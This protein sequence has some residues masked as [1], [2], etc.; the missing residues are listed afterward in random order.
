MGSGSDLSYAKEIAETLKALE[1]PVKAKIMSAHKLTEELLMT[2]RDY[3]IQEN[4][5]IFY[6]AI[7][8]RSN[9]L[10]GVIEANTLSPV[11]NAPPYSDKFGGMDILSSLRMPS[12]MS[13]ATVLEPEG[14][15][16]HIARNFAL[17]N[18]ELSDRLAMYLERS[19]NKVR[20]ANKLL[21]ENGL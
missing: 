14:A 2:V 8:G 7:A 5:S 10:G 4:K 18:P 3:N 20:E 9:A 1:I 15:A 21:E 12:G 17:N 16:L 13:G 11:I 6:V 19:R